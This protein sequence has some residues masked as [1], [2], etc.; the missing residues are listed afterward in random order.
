MNGTTRVAELRQRYRA[1]LSYTFELNLL[2]EA[3]DARQSFLDG[4]RTGYLTGD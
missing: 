3:S 4:R 2:G 1:E